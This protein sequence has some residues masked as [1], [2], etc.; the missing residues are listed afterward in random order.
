MEQSFLAWVRGRVRKLP[1][2]AVGIGDD[3]AVLDWPSDQQMVT[4]VDTITDGVD[5]VLAD[6]ALADIGHKAIAVNLSDIAAMGAR[7]TA[8]LIAIS[9]PEHGA[10][11][12][13]AGVY[14]GI[15]ATA[16]R[17]GVA[18]AGGD[19]TCYDGPLSISITLIRFS[20]TLFT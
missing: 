9:L 3:A 1:Q 12:T 15:L 5:F 18:I 11:E 17:Y 6:H 10:T 2:V 13:A 16:D 8:A 7:P 19:I 4:C 20:M 14:D